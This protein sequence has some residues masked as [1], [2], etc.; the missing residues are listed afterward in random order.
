[1]SSGVFS[2]SKVSRKVFAPSRLSAGASSTDAGRILIVTD[3]GH[4]SAAALL[5]S[6]LE[7]DTYYEGVA[8]AGLQLADD[9]ANVLHLPGRRCANT[10]CLR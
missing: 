8:A 2:P 7:D 1:M 6:T 3:G 9:V 10:L 4:R 5:V